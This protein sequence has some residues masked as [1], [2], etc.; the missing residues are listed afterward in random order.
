MT[1]PSKN[2]SERAERCN[3]STTAPSCARRQRQWRK[4]AQLHAAARAV[5]KV[6]RDKG[7]GAGKRAWH[8]YRCSAE[9]QRSGQPT[10]G[11]S[12]KGCDCSRILSASTHSSSSGKSRAWEKIQTEKEKHF[13]EVANMYTGV[14]CQLAARSDGTG[15]VVRACPAGFGISRRECARKGEAGGQSA[16]EQGS[17][18]SRS[19]QCAAQYHTK[20][21]RKSV[22]RGLAPPTSCRCRDC[23]SPSKTVP[24]RFPRHRAQCQITQRQIGWAIPRLDSAAREARS[25]KG[26]APLQLTPPAVCGRG[27]R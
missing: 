11:R 24:S 19:P 6:I 1:T 25:P 21:H 9:G 3:A 16:P 18:S 13:K 26:R 14:P 22:P 20:R 4:H 8:K 17:G 15:A 27:L 5:E 12:S 10:L 7:N 2:K 23:P